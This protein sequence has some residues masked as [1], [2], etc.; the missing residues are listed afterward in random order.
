M[1]L[2]QQLIMLV[3]V[4]ILGLASLG[5][6]GLYSIRTSLIDARKHELETTLTFAEKQVEPVIKAESLGEISRK[7]AEEKV[8]QILSQYQ[9][10]DSY[11]WSN[12]EHAIAR[13]H[14]KKEKIG[15]FQSSNKKYLDELQNKKFIFA[16][17]KS[18]K[19]GTQEQILK[20]NAVAK[21][22]KW[23]WVMGIGVYMDDLSNAYWDFAIKFILISIS[24]IVIIAFT[25]V[26]IS[27]SILT[28]LGGEPDYAVAITSKIAKGSL[29]EIIEGSFKKDSLL[30]SINLM[31]T[32]LKE[33]VESIQKASSS[34]H[35]SSKQLMSEFTVINESSQKSSD[36]SI[37]TSAAIQELSNC[38]QEISLNAQ[39]T[40][41]NS[42]DSYN[43]SNS[44]VA[45][46]HDSN[47]TIE[48]MSEKIEYSVSDF[49]KLQD[50]IDSIGN[51]VEVINDIAGQTNLLALNAAIEAARAGEQGRGFAVVADEVRTLASRTASATDEIT[52]TIDI[53]QKDTDAVAHALSSVL[54][55]VEENKAISGSV[56]DVFQEISTSTNK[57]LSMTRE[58]SSAT[59]EQQVASDELARNVELISEMVRD[60]A[61][62][63]SSCNDTV[64]ELDVLSKEL[65]KHV[66][67]FSIKH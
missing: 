19:P 61:K 6:Y 24:M 1:K 29:N 4:V 13:V 46:I 3:V 51:I 34:L 35:V 56:S 44:G 50:K 63:V 11:I 31:Q 8:T 59:G 30:G 26:Y 64:L 43:T 17:S 54:P 48:S 41:N 60:T 21:I 39:E 9:Y 28:K 36:A 47:Q 55:M 22:P 27:R 5:S 15:Q 14:I 33:M 20:I 65:L 12:D 53:I 42:Q 67:K 32:S 40:E 38:I 10:G 45:L 57:T 58:V 25:V 62:S 66:S 37:S 16:V 49:K 18:L 23:N 7:N 2:S 52:S